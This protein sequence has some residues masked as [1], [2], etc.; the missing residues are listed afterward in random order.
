MQDL[1]W[2]WP[3]SSPEGVKASETV[4]PVVVPDL[5]T[6]EFGGQWYARDLPY[7]FDTLVENLV[8]EWE[9]LHFAQLVKLR[10]ESNTLLLH[11][12]GICMRRVED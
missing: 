9:H 12:C 3:D 11:P 4:S 6:G 1:L 10:E 2:L 5:N 8:G 7:G